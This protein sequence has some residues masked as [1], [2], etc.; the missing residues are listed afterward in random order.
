MDRGAGGSGR[1]GHPFALRVLSFSQMVVSP[2]KPCPFSLSAFINANDPALG[3]FLKGGGAVGPAA[4]CSG[5]LIEA[6]RFPYVSSLM[7]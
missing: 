4:C 3:L 7:Q 5:E 1:L 6:H 2:A